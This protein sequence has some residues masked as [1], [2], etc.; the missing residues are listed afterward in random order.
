MRN[1]PAISLFG[2]FHPFGIKQKSVL[3]ALLVVFSVVLGSG[4]SILFMTA[5]DTP[6]IRQK[7]KILATLQ[8]SE[9]SLK[10]SAENLRKA[11]ALYLLA[12]KGKSPSTAASQNVNVGDV[13]QVPKELRPPTGVDRLKRILSVGKP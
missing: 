3:I 11:E 4:L 2:R 1:L 6:A 12:V 8:D 5:R 10:R 7:K 9:E 13:L